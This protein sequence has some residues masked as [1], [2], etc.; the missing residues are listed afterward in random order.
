[1]ADSLEV[2]A[3]PLRSCAGVPRVMLITGGGRGI[4]A[5]CA[6]RAARAGYDVCLSYVSRE[7]DARAVADECRALGVRAICVAADVSVDADV[8]RLFEQAETALGKLGCLV[9]NAGIV[10]RAAPLASFDDA[11]VRRIFD[12]NVIGSFACAREAVRRMST[13]NGGCGGNIVNISSAAAYLGS[14]DEYIDYA[15]SKAAVDT[16][17]IGLAKEVARQGI[18]VNAVR[19]GLIHTDIHGDSGDPDRVAR[20]APGVP[21]GRGGTPDEVA[22]LVLWLASDEASFVTGSLVNCSGGR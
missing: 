6:R 11:R 1:V 8:V 2:S 3:E 10:A 9:N 12:V 19:P 20:L 21:L 5:A 14:P 17:T 18:R 7:V 13:S 16:L 15:A 4:G 22:A